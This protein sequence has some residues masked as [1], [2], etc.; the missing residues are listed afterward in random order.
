MVPGEQGPI[1]G[2]GAGPR[3]SVHRGD[4]PPARRGSVATSSRRPGRS[5]GRS[6]GST[7]TRGS[8]RTRARTRPR[9]GSISA[10]TPP[11]RAS[12]SR[13]SSSTWTR[14]RPCSRRGSGSPR[15]RPPRRSGTRSSPSPAAWAKLR[16]GGITVEGESYVRV[17][18]GYSSRPPVRRRPPPEG[19]L[20][21]PPL[22]RRRGHR[23]GVRQGVPLRLRGAQ[24]VERLPREGDRRPLVSAG[25]PTPA[26]PVRPKEMT[27]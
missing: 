21:E 3:A 8:R 23:Q 26:G 11:P 4:D 12:T 5:A 1:R 24:P 6:C 7:G 9:S 13:G 2:V 15:P 10:T 17:P 18:A 27:T 22:L 20:R 19:L 25:A 16:K 14:R